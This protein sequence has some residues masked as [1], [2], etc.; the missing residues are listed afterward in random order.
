MV[1]SEPHRCSVYANALQTQTQ[2]LDPTIT[3]YSIRD[4]RFPTSL[5]A[6]GSDPMKW[7]GL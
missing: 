2:T 4:L 1:S 6:I 5:D 3:G 7:V